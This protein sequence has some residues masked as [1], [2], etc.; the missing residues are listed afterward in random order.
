MTWMCMVLL[1]ALG[2]DATP[3]RTLN[4]RHPDWGTWVWRFGNAMGIPDV[5]ERVLDAAE[6][7]K[8]LIYIENDSGFSGEL[9]RIV[10]ERGGFEGTSGQLLELFKSSAD[11]SGEKF[12]LSAKGLGRKLTSGWPYYIRVLKAKKRK[13]NGIAIYTL[14]PPE[15]GDELAE[16]SAGTAEVGGDNTND[17]ADGQDLL[18]VG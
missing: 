12:R 13:S 7:E 16:H 18:P 2:S 10:R 14:S 17:N 15:D 4:R 9:V 11:A 8:S 5:A 3:P 6:K 1:N